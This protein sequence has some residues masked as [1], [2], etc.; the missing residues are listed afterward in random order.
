MS[1]QNPAACRL[2]APFCGQVG[3]PLIR[4]FILRIVLLLLPSGA[5]ASDHAD[6]IDPFSREQLEAGSTDLFVFPIDENGMPVHPFKRTDG[7][8]LER[9]DLSPR[10]ALTDEQRA[11]IKDLI[12]ILCVRR[13]LT[14]SGKLNLEPY[15]YRI[16]FDLHS[17]VSF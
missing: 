4:L 15:R 8:S 11:Q 9:P 7:I 5:P 13:Q 10:P 3:W 1:N 16:H 2:R 17:T 14:Q 6:P 12:V